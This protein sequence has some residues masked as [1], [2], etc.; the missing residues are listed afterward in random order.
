MQDDFAEWE[1]EQITL[2]TAAGRREKARQGEVIAGRLPDH[3]FRSGPDRES[4]EVAEEE[5]AKALSSS[6]V[7]DA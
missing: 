5:K 2:R 4:Y 6:T 1:R 3:G 7:C